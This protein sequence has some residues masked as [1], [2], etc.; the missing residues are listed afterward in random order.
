MEFDTHWIVGDVLSNDSRSRVLVLHG[1]GESDRRRFRPLRERLFREGI[2]SAAFDFVGHGD[3]GGDLKGAS[4]E[5]RTRQARAVID[6]LNF[7][8]PLRVIGASMGAYTAVKLLAHCE[9]DRL[10]LLVPA[11]YASRAYTAPFNGEFTKIIRTAKSWESSDAWDLIEKYTGRILTIS[12]EKDAVIPKGVPE[13]IHASAVNAERREWRVAPDASHFVFSDLRARDPGELERLFAR[14]VDYLSPT[15]SQGE[16][17][18]RK[19]RR[20]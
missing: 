12:G 18:P 11:M 8:S 5:N 13:K 19:N 9:I 16:S 3:T 17:P 14:I 1:A 2:S 20:S 7:E 4:L 10:I 15:P 6:S